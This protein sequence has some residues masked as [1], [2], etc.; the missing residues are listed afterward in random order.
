MTVHFWFH[1]DS[2]LQLTLNK[3]SDAAMLFSLIISLNKTER[4]ALYQLCQVLSQ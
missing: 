3:F 2:D 1:K 4:Q